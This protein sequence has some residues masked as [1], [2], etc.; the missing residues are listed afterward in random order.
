MDPKFFWVVTQL[1]HPKGN[2]KNFCVGWWIF[3][4]LNVIFIRIQHTFRYLHHVMT[5]YLQF[6]HVSGL[7]DFPL[8]SKLLL[9]YK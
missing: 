1:I 8:V 9:T 2:P 4:I 3:H 6:D 5:N 7:K